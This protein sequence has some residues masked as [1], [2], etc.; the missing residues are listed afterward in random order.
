M[1]QEARELVAEIKT[2]GHQNGLQVNSLALDCFDDQGLDKLNRMTRLF[3][4]IV[5][6]QANS[7]GSEGRNRKFESVVFGSGRP[8]LIVPYVQTRPASLNSIVVAWDGSAPAARAL[9][10]SLRCS[11]ERIGSSSSTSAQSR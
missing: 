4:T 2:K 3:D 7:E 5:M 10:D 6:E 8:I 9:G 1:L 11:R